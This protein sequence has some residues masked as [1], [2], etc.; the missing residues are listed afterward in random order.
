MA[1]SFFLS[2]RARWGSTGESIYVHRCGVDL[3]SSWDQT[4]CRQSRCSWT[5]VSPAS[6]TWTVKPPRLRSHS[7][8]WYRPLQKHTQLMRTSLVPIV[9]L[10]VLS[11]TDIKDDP[12][13]PI[14]PLLP[15]YFGLTIARDPT[16]PWTPALVPLAASQ[17]YLCLLVWSSCWMHIA[18]YPC[19]PLPCPHTQ[20]E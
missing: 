6:G 16:F 18:I 14:H 10:H 20:I 3:S 7:C 17:T 5:P 13:R 2:G 9:N 4:L 12:Q 11:F 19:P 8:C 15:S 1:S